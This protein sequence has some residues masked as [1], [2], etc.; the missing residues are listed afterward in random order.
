MFFNLFIPERH[1]V[2]HVEPKEVRAEPEPELGAAWFFFNRGGA[3]DAAELPSPERRC[4]LY[5]RNGIIFDNIVEINFRSAGAVI[6]FTHFVDIPR[7][8]NHATAMFQVEVCVAH[9]EV[10]GL[11]WIASLVDLPVGYG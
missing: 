1:V 11:S 3:V 8:G 5:M 9:A 7:G 2:Q 4:K 6:K 10:I